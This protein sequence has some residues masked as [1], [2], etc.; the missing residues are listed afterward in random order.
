MKKERWSPCCGGQNIKLFFGIG[1][2]IP[3]LCATESY[4]VIKIKPCEQLRLFGLLGNFQS[5]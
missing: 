5:A 1:L 4:P 2:Q 3:E